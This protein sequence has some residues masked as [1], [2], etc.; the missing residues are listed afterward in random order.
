M[1][2]SGRGSNLAAILDA[3]LAVAL[4]VSNRANVPALAIAERHGVPAIVLRRS[5]FDGDADARDAAIGT[6]L[7]DAG[8]TLAVLA[9]YDQRLGS[10]YFAAFRGRTLN[11]HPSLLPRHGGAGMLGLAVH[12]A[13]LASGDT[14]TGVTI[15]EVTPEVDAGPI[16]AQASV[17]VVPGERPEELAARV[18]EV[19]HRL[20]VSTLAD[21]VGKG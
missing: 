21:L 18:L 17:P 15:H 16:I 10:S 3:K 7:T 2:V 4:V 8:V 5:A 13:V 11:I 9:G 20:L 6:A 12:A 14:T 19:E 1:L